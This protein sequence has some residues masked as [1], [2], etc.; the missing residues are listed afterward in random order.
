MADSMNQ[1]FVTMPLEQLDI[2]EL[3]CLEY[4]LRLR[5]PRLRAVAGG[6]AW[7][8]SAT[9]A[10]WALVFRDIG[11][12]SRIFGGVSGSWRSWSKLCPNLETPPRLRTP[13]PLAPVLTPTVSI[14]F[15]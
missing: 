1:G 13:R 7:V 14:G 12:A 4:R 5:G 11:V 2:G 9:W 10:S 6:S 15:Q 8:W 3:G